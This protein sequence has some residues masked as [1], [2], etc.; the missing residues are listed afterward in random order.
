MREYLGNEAAVY[1]AP[2]VCKDGFDFACCSARGMVVNDV[3]IASCS[4]LETLAQPL[5]TS[6]DPYLVGYITADCSLIVG[7]DQFRKEGKEVV[8]KG[9]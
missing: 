5:N 2:L 7:L 8:W 9:L 1:P 4:T 6:L 3:A